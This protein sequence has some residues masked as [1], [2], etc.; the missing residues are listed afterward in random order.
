MLRKIYFNISYLFEKQFYLLYFI[1]ALIKQFVIS[2]I[3]IIFFLKKNKI[4]F[5]TKKFYWRKK[6]PTKFLF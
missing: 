5:F 3:K 2:N 6:N 1:I 4:N